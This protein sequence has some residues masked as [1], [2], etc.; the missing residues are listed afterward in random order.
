MSQEHLNNGPRMNE[1]STNVE[2]DSLEMNGKYTNILQFRLFW[3]EIPLNI[4]SNSL[5]VP[6]N[7]ANIHQ[8]GVNL[9]ANA[10][11]LQANGTQNERTNVTDMNVEPQPKRVNLTGYGPIIC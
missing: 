11:D 9:Q 1:N 5:H 4:H 6:Q 3:L 2:H 10:T 8:F 7:G